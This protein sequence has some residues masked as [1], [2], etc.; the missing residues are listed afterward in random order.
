MKDKYELDSLINTYNDLWKRNEEKKNINADN[1]K[2][3][4]IL[5]TYTVYGKV[6]EMFKI[7]FHKPKFVFNKVYTL[8]K[9]NKQ[10][11]VTAFSGLLE[12]SKRNKITTKQEKTFGNII[13]EKNN[14]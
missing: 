3:I 10:E 9:C 2:K 14:K 12:L 5:D 1:I 8:T 11:L 6:K 7:L 13:V 4:A